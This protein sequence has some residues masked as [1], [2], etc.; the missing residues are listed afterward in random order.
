MPVPVEI[1]RPGG[2]EKE[3][4]TISV[5]VIIP[6]F[7]SQSIEISEDEESEE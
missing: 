1:Q 5:E 2:E 4:E 7:D 6:D 3:A